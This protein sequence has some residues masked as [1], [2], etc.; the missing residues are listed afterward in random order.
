MRLTAYFLILSISGFG[1]TSHASKE[2]LTAACGVSMN[3]RDAAS[4]KGASPAL[5]EF[6]RDSLKPSPSGLRFRNYYD[7]QQN[8]QSSGRLTVNRRGA[9]ALKSRQKD[10]GKKS[11]F[12]GVVI[13]CA[14][15]GEGACALYRSKEADDALFCAGNNCKGECDMQMEVIM[16][17]PPIQVKI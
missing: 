17:E 3:I 11:P 8:S 16:G 7:F 4:A 5:K 6:L 2:V 12:N 1:T 13:N 14:C 9:E 10:H 15:P